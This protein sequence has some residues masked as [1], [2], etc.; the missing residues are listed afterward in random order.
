MKGFFPAAA[1]R[2]ATLF[3]AAALALV[4]AVT[5]SAPAQDH[6]PTAALR[7]RYALLADR[8][9][10]SSFHQR[11]LLESAESQHGL[12]GDAWA[13]VDYP[14][15]AVAATVTNPAH[16]CDAL[17]LHLNIKYC[18]PVSHGSGAALSVSIGRKYDQA[19]HDAFHLDFECRVV[20][21]GPDYVAVDLSSAKGP[22]ATT[23]YRITLEAIALAPGRSFVHLRYSYQFGFEARLAMD[24]YLATAGS[25]KVGFTRIDVPGEAQPRYIG[26]MR[27]VVERNTMRYF[28]AIDAYLATL[29]APPLQRLDVSLERWFA[30]TER[31]PRQLHEVDRETYLA[32]KHREYQRQQA[33]P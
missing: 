30:A 14:L 28:L 2:C 8:I 19:L 17:I 20:A 11:L 5:A 21:A 10:H 7:S 24:A 32:M 23:D 12:Q 31:Y 6:D 27:G 4:A 13:V 22:L 16:W 33:P 25:G 15:A 18:R 9:E 26:G 29:A 3:G 1:R